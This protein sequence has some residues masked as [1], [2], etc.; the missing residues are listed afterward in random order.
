LRTISIAGSFG[1]LRC[2][3]SAS[4]RDSAGLNGRTMKSEMC[5][6]TATSGTIAMPRF[7]ATALF[8]A[9]T[10]PSGTGSRA[11]ARPDSQPRTSA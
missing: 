10:V 8:T 6:A 5:G 1:L 9:Y 11:G 7:D 2:S 4:V 3:M